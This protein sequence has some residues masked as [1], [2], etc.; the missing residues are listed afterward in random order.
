MCIFADKEEIG[1]EGVSGMMSEA[2]D[3]FMESM[4]RTQ[5]VDLRTCYSKSFCLSADVTAAYD[6]NFPRGL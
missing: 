1:S 5:G 2:F 3:Y 4:C 6:P